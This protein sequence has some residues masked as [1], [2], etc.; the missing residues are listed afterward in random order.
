ME[1]G[2]K[3]NFNSVAGDLEDGKVLSAELV[4]KVFKYFFDVAEGLCRQPDVKTDKTGS[5]LNIENG[6]FVYYNMKGDR[7]EKGDQGIKGEKGAAYRFQGEYSVADTYTCDGNFI[8][9][10]RYNGNLYVCKS[11]GCI[12]KLPTDSNYWGLMAE[13]GTQGE[14]GRNAVVG[15]TDGMIYFDVNADGDLIV[16]CNDS[17]EASHFSIENGELIYRIE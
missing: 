6:R 17:N 4:R 1:N 9:T 14:P 15:E 2:E 7:G 3:F 12:G 11:N 10:V 5:W 8:D 16:H 13:R